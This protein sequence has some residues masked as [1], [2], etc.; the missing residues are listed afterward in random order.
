MHHHQIILN[1]MANNCFGI[2]LQ[3]LRFKKVHTTQLLR[4]EEIIE[5]AKSY[6]KDTK[7]KYDVTT[8]K[9]SKKGGCFVIEIPVEMDN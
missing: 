9:D 2:E 7:I 4:M 6:N 8:L 1:F 5:K 3:Q